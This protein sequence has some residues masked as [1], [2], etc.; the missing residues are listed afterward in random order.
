VV[1]FAAGVGSPFF[2][3]DTT[4]A[5]RANEIGADVVF[6]ATKVDGVYDADPKT[7]PRAKRYEILHY[8]DALNQQLRIM[9]STAFSLCMDNKLPLMVFDMVKPHNIKNAVLGRSVGTLLSADDDVITQYH[10]NSGAEN[11]T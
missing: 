1:I 9:D 10:A 6:K 2:S 7:N 4:A 5:L 3:T 11:S 8:R